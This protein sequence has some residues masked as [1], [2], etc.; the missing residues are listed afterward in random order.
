M[1]GSLRT[2]ACGEHSRCGQAGSGS[3]ETSQSVW[4]SVGL[5]VGSGDVLG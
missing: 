5:G 3:M 4:L 1:A 2:T